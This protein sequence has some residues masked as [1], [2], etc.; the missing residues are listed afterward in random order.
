MQKPPSKPNEENP[1][2]QSQMFEQEEP[3]R[4]LEVVPLDEH[5]RPIEKKKPP[6]V[7]AAGPPGAKGRKKSRVLVEGSPEQLDFLVE[8]IKD[9]RNQGVTDLKVSS[10]SEEFV[11]LERT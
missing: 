10:R 9:L 8:V 11:V 5:G 2:D 1:E 4:E 3:P 6:T 7:P